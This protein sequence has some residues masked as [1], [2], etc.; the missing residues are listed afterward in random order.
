MKDNTTSTVMKS[1]HS[2][3]SHKE[4]II[5]PGDVTVDVK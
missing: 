4:G 5:L 3:G 2:T 1:F